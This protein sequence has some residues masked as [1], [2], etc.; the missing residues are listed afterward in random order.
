MRKIIVI[1]LLGALLLSGCAKKGGTGTNVTVPTVQPAANGTQQPAANATQPAA[2]T[3]PTQP[4][5][6]V[7]P[8]P[9]QNTTQPPANVTPPA[10]NTTP[11]QNVTQPPQNTTAPPQNTS[12]TSVDDKLD[13]G[14]GMFD[15]TV[16]PL[17]TDSG[18]D[19]TVPK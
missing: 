6:N 18:Y 9:A 5:Q 13:A 16:D 14:L 2:N 10:Q 8:P 12:G 19:G 7:T 3:T 1:L 15:Y 17:M 11:P 4:A